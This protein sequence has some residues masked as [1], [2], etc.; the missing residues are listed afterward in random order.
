MAKYCNLKLILI[1]LAVYAHLFEP[2][3]LSSRFLAVQYKVIY[4]FHMP[5][6]SFVSG[7]FIKDCLMAL[8][9][10]RKAL[11]YYLVL[12][13]FCMAF[14][15]ETSIFVPYWHLWYLL[16]LALWSGAAWLWLR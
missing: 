16:S 14:F 10:M 5:A 6:F 8:A 1:F 15:K 9:Q 12:Q 2:Q 7:M 3:I 13:I 4:L 11:G